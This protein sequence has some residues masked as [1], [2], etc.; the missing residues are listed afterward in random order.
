M[1]LYSL[2]CCSGLR[3]SVCVSCTYLYNGRYTSYTTMLLTPS[4]QPQAL[5]RHRNTCRSRQ[6]NTITC[7]T[8]ERYGKQPKFS[9]VL[10][11]PCSTSPAQAANALQ[12]PALLHSSQETHRTALSRTRTA[13]TSRL[14][15]RSGPLPLRHRS[16]ATPTRLREQDC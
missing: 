1:Y 4:R 13:D 10:L 14:L 2:P 11:Q 7:P 9:D 16:I 3:S 5:G 15:C 8:D 12:R 6:S